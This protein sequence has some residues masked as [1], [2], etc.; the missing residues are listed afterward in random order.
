MLEDHRTIDICLFLFISYSFHFSLKHW[1]PSVSIGLRRYRGGGRFLSSPDSDWLTDMGGGVK[2]LKNYKKTITNT[3]IQ[4]HKT[5]K[6]IKFDWLTDMEGSEA[7]WEL[8][9]GNYKNTKTR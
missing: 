9:K 3:Q 8:Q 4:D 7:L 5:M 1:P 6:N 2:H